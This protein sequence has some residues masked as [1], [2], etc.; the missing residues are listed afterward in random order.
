M[1]S[2]ATCEVTFLLFFPEES[3]LSFLEL[4]PFVLWLGVL[5]QRRWTDIPNCVIHFC[6]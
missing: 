2:R 4:F 5:E 6:V 1:I 3:S